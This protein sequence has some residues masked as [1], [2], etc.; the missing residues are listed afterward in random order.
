MGDTRANRPLPDWLAAKLKSNPSLAAENPG[1]AIERQAS[2]PP[3]SGFT[4]V[5]TAKKRKKTR[6]EAEMEVTLSIQRDRLQ[7]A[8]FGFEQITLVIG[9]PPIRYTP[10]FTVWLPCGRLR[11]I[12]VKGPYIREDAMIKFRNARLLFPLAE[13]QLW[14]RNKQGEWK[15]LI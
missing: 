9:S 3:D 15:Q 2:N 5:R 10:D 12:E 11:F 13:W 7:I 14:Q 8:S 4:K 1:I 6:P